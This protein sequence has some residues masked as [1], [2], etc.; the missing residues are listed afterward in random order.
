MTGTATTAFPIF[1]AAAREQEPLIV[2]VHDV[3]PV[4]RSSSER[5][6]QELARRGVRVCSLLVVPDYHRTGSSMGER[7][8][9]QWLRDLEAAGH[10]IVIHG[11]YHER[12]RREN[13]RLGTKLITRI[14][15]ADEGEFFDLEYEEAFRR[16]ARARAEFIAAG[17]KPH[18][19]IAPAWLLSREAERAAVDAGME[20]TTRLTSVLDL[21]TAQSFHSRSLVYSARNAWRR[22]TSLAWNG[23][24]ARLLANA[25]LLRLGLHPPDC[26]HAEIWQQVTRLLDRLSE[27]RTPT[28]YRDWIAENRV[29]NGQT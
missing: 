19:F 25:P 24:A 8:F 26:E 22:A 6:V 12:P 2:S 16:I 7:D 3:A 10:E 15:T 21:R 20:Y 28:T 4:T 5:I 14:Y 11:Y 1:A 23:A 18:G 27:T 13:E 9:V 29:N 17:L